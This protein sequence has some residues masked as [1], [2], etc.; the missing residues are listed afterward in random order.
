MLTS[1][2]ER[3]K[4]WEGYEG[5]E[6]GLGVMRRRGRRESHWRR[7]VGRIRQNKRKRTG[8]DTASDP[9]CR[10]VVFQCLILFVAEGIGGRLI[11]GFKLRWD[12]RL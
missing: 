10:R 9:N 2:D 3:D 8:A 6:E 11:L 4:L 5:S 12:Y 1:G 7:R